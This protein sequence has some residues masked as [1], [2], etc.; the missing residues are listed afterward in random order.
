MNVRRLRLT[1]ALLAGIALPIGTARA[2]SADT[3]ICQVRSITPS[4]GSAASDPRLSDIQGILASL[5]FKSFALVAADVLRIP[6]GSTSGSLT[7]PDGKKLEITYLSRIAAPKPR[8]RFQ[9]VVRP[10]REGARPDVSTTFVL[11]DGGTVLQMLDAGSAPLLVAE[12]CKA[13]S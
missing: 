6:L 5:P 8:V 13:T 10:A 4:H 7:L 11:D 1:G 2:A 9:L 12:T 3:A